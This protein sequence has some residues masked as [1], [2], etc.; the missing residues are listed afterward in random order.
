MI[1]NSGKFVC[2]KQINK[3]NNNKKITRIRVKFYAVLSF[4]HCLHTLLYL[5]VNDN[6]N[7]IYQLSLS[8]K[9]F[10]DRRLSP[11]PFRSKTDYFARQH[12][13]GG[14]GE[15]LVGIVGERTG[16]VLNIIISSK[17]LHG[18]LIPPSSSRH[19]AL[20]INETRSPCISIWKQHSDDKACSFGDIL[21]RDTSLSVLF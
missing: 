9:Y 12:W 14:E 10:S 1:I 7:V 5:I 11:P 18:V 2:M 21:E 15:T 17:Y 16:A 3:P 4:F 19:P 13:E 20:E 6:N 8:L